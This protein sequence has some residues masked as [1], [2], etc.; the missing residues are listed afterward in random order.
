VGV[1]SISGTLSYPADSL[2]AMRVAAFDTT[3][4]QPYWVDTQAGQSDYQ[5]PNV[6]A[7]TYFVVAYSLGGGS[8]PP[9]MAGGYSAAVPCGMTDACTDHSLLPVAVQ[10]G[11]ETSGIRPADWNGG[12]FPP[13]PGPAAIQDAT[14]PAGP[15]SD[16]KSVIEGRLSYPSSFIPPLAVVAFNVND[17]NDFHF[18]L[19]QQ[20]Q[21]TYSLPVPD[22][23]YYVV[24]YVQG[25]DF[26]GA[27][28]QAVPCGLSVNC[29]DHSLI[30]VAVANGSPATGIDP[31]DWYAPEGTFPPNPVK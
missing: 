13:M 11:N 20:D 14:A 9:G 6:P 30:P 23:Q 2:P 3:T 17:P 16:A 22:G 4:S 29:T 28:S 5:I 19:T 25:G 1:G 18:V 10:T 15:G 12:T 21:A 26:A 24:S 27:Y 8:F 7:G 31:G